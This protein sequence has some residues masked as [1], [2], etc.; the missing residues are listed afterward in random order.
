MPLL[1]DFLFSK[2]PLAVLSN[3]PKSGISGIGIIQEIRPS[4]ISITTSIIVS[5]MSV[6]ISIARLKAKKFY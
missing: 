4:T 5:T 3:S 6:I 2:T 1:E